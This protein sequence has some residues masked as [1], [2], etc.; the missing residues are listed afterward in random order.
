MI[1]IQSWF[2]LVLLWVHS[3]TSSNQPE[4]ETRVVKGENALLGQFPYQVLLI[5][6][7]NDGK[8]A[9]CGGTLISDEWVLTAGHCVQDA[10]SFNITLGAIDLKQQSPDGRVVVSSSV[11]I[12][13][14]NYQ[15]GSATNDVAVIKL[16]SKITL[17][18][19]IQPAKLPDGNDSYYEQEVIVSGF[20]QQKDNGS[21]TQKLQ[22]AKLVVILN[23][24]CM[25]VYGPFAIKSTNICA[26]DRNGASACHGDS[27]G[28]LVLA[29]DHT[30]VGVVSFGNVLGCEKRLP[31]A[32]S[33]VTKFRDWIRAHTGV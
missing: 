20:G 13:H 25:L 9:L 3:G 33:R 27:G 18:D 30:L 1:S 16:P 19:F 10:K 4:D 7:L 12:R 15:A 22:Y 14:E 29:S 24:E 26:W 6:R 8:G 32:Y 23:A 5:I 28:P 31:V 2:L 21:V 11:Y 17:T